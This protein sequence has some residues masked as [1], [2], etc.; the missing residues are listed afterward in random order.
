MEVDLLTQAPNTSTCTW[1]AE[2]GGCYK[3]KA[4]LNYRVRFC[5]KKKKI[6]K[7]IPLNMTVENS[8]ILRLLSLG[9][10][11]RATYIP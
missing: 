4:R 7:P 3:F 10:G 1:E 6:K 8:G 9:I 2:A 5:L 11:Y